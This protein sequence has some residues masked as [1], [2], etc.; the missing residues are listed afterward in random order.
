MG[1][2]EPAAAERLQ[3]AALELFARQGYE[4]TTAAEIAQ[5]VGLSERTFFRHFADKRE[6]LFR[7]QDE[8]EAAFLEGLAAVPAD[9]PAMAAVAAAVRAGAAWFVDERRDHS[10]LRQVVIDANP[11]LLER[12]R[13]K[14]AGLATSLA[15]ALRERGVTE[16]AATLAAE[17]G[18][19]VFG[20]AFGLWIG[21][22]EQRSLREIADSVLAELA[23]VTGTP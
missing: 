15:S 19:T 14:M 2:W 4:R 11:P 13:H 23:A 16:P 6:V 9:A 8:F 22:G 7:G 12:E 1:R 10:R 3:H 5:S 17:S 21:E 20:I 18:A